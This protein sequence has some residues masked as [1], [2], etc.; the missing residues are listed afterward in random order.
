MPR[1]SALGLILLSLLILQVLCASALTTSAAEVNNHWAILIGVD[2]YQFAKPL[3]YCGR[4]QKSLRSQLIRSGFDER[5]VFLLHDEAELQRFTPT[6]RNI[7]KQLELL[8]G[9]VKEGDMVLLSFSGH[10]LQVGGENFLCP[11]D[12]ELN[13]PESMIPTDAIYEMLKGC[14]ASLKVMLVDACRNDPFP[15]GGRNLGANPA[16]NAW[17]EELKNEPPEGIVLLNSCAPGEISWEDDAYRHGVFMYYVLDALGG[18]ADRNGDKLVS[19]G[20]LVRYASEETELR[21]MHTRATKQEPFVTSEAALEAL[22]FG[23]KVSRN[24]EIQLQRWMNQFEAKPSVTFSVPSEFNSIAEFKGF[25]EELYRNHGKPTPGMSRTDLVLLNKKLAATVSLGLIRVSKLGMSEKDQQYH[26]ATLIHSLQV[27][28]KEHHPAAQD[29]LTDAIQ[30]AL[31][32]GDTEMRAVGMKCYIDFCAKTWPALNESEKDD[33]VLAFLDYLSQ[34][35]P[36]KLYFA[37]AYTLM[38]ILEQV[39]AMNQLETLLIGLLDY[40]A[41]STD[42]QIIDRTQNLRGRLNRLDLEGK[43]PEIDGELLD[44]RPLNWRDYRGKVVLLNFWHDCDDCEVVHEVLKKCYES[45]REK[46]FEILDVT[47]NN[48]LVTPEIRDRNSAKRYWERNSIPWS[49]IYHDAGWR[50]PLAVRLGMIRLPTLILFDRNGVVVHSNLR[51]QEIPRELTKLLGNPTNGTLAELQQFI[52]R[53]GEQHLM[54]KLEKM[55]ERQRTTADRMTG[56]P[57]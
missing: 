3:K 35:T 12:G 40:F 7:E 29:A 17:L 6:K 38:G 2:K 27:L 11:V 55:K 21:V 34:E 54:K 36:S 50:Q 48:D 23:L 26:F 16:A 14:P 28:A 10:G 41:V 9:L 31:Q 37:Q 1:L 51:V 5:R 42:A 57:R 19:L 46:G 22:D 47:I 45:Y 8:L 18:A 44:G 53:R 15:G 56:L 43:K 49:T 33:L 32:D 24:H 13:K 39:G 4:D 20:E 25:L 52:K 30:I